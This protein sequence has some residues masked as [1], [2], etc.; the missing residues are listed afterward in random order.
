MKEQK[1]T[2]TKEI[3]KWNIR[4]IENSDENPNLQE[5]GQKKLCET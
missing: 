3:I 1:T 2:I 4:V 5:D